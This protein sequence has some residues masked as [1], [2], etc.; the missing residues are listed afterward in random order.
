LDDFL[1]LSIRLA[2]FVQLEHADLRTDSGQDPLRVLDLPV[3]QPL[4]Q[5]VVALAD[6]FHDVAADH[7]IHI[8]GVEEREIGG[9][10]QSLDRDASAL[11]FVRIADDMPAPV[12]PHDPV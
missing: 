3:G 10:I 2:P 5:G 7:P 1:R 11:G 4:D 12:S 9:R 8:V 6:Q